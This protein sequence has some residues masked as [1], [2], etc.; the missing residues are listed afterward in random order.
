MGNFDY[1]TELHGRDLVQELLSKC[2]KEQ[3]VFFERVFPGGV[4]GL[5]GDKI[6][7]AYELCE[8]TI[9]DNNKKAVAKNG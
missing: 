8:R 6:K 4:D 1:Q 2:T 3:Q 7:T 5:K 9:K